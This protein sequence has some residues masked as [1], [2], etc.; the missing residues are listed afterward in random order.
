MDLEFNE[1]Q[2][3]IAAGVDQLVGRHTLSV[4]ME[5]AVYQLSPALERELVDSDF[6]NVAR[7]DGLGALE[8]LIVIEGLARSPFAVETTASALVGPVLGL[9]ALPRPVSLVGPPHDA[10]VRFLAEEGA[11]LIDMGDEIRLIAGRELAVSPVTSLY[12]YPMGR[13]GAVDLA[14]AGEA[15]DVDPEAFRHLWRLGLAAEIVGAMQMALDLTVDHVKTRQQFGHPLG[16]FQAIQHRL[17]ECHMAVQGSRLLVREAA[18]QDSRDGAA[19]AA[20]YAQEAAARLVYET[21]QF[22]GAMGLTLEYPLHYWTYRL[23]V[24]QGEL[25]GIN[26]QARLGAELAWPV[27]EPIAETFRGQ[28]V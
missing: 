25:G 2:N 11:A 1:D 27:S 18:S 19:L 8:A 23:R 4:S 6:L 15:L 14:S 20:T 10:P 26:A 17:S 5:P 16:T 12:A 9:E 22:H 3:A 21:Q 13:I 7:W 28:V 24:L